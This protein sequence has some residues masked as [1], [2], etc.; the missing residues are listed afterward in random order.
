MRLAADHLPCADVHIV[1][2]NLIIIVTCKKL[3]C[4]EN[5]TVTNPWLSHI[6]KELCHF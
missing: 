4:R 5:L 3:E 1:L 6:F 2:K